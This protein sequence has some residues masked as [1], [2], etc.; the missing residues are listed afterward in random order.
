MYSLVSR[1]VNIEKP[2]Q[3]RQISMQI[4]MAKPRS[5]MVCRTELWPE[6]VSLVLVE[7]VHRRKDRIYGESRGCGRGTDLTRSAWKEIK[8][9]LDAR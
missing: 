5:T 4:T 8:T 1:D 2:V 9:I 7:E 6:D 3:S